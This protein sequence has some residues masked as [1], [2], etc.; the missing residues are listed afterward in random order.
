MF[1]EIDNDCAQP[2][3]ADMWVGLDQNVFRCPAGNQCLKYDEY[4]RMIQACSQFAIGKGPGAA[5]TELYIA[6]RIKLAGHPELLNV[7][8]TLFQRP[9]TIDK[10]HAHAGFSKAFGGEKAGGPRADH[11]GVMTGSYPGKHHP[12]SIRHLLESTG[13]ML[14][15]KS[16]LVGKRKLN[17]IDS[18]YPV[19]LTSINGTP[20]DPE[21]R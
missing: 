14:L 8:H 4:L 17:R 19:L 7:L 6:D 12:G 16:R 18:K 2:I 9:S 13:T 1:P 10:S 15:Q 11:Q 3:R 20:D 5:F 21:A